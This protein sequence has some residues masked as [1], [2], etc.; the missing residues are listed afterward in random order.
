MYTIKLPNYNIRGPTQN[1]QFL[2]MILSQNDPEFYGFFMIL[3]IILCF[4]MLMGNKTEA[5]QEEL[6]IFK[7]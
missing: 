5:K 4:F 7:T 6:R 1:S 3:V 2:F